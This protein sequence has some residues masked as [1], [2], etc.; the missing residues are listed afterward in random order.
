MESNRKKDPELAGYLRNIILGSGL[1]NEH[2]AAE[3]N[4]SPRIIS[5]YCNGERKP[6]Q[7]T[8]LRLLRVTNVE[9]KDI[10]F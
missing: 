9:V 3:L 1:S 2:I 7:K 4:V 6:G 8:L 5:F 10:P